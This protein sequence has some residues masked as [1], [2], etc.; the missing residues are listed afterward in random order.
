MMFNEPGEK[1]KKI[2]YANENWLPEAGMLE[3]HSTTDRRN[4]WFDNLPIF[5]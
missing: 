1:P 2:E 5:K 3:I 4:I